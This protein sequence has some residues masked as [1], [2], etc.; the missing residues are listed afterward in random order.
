MAYP[1]YPGEVDGALQ[2]NKRPRTEGEGEVPGQGD[3]ANREVLRK[4]LT[5]MN[6][7]QLIDLLIDM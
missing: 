1:A 3:E 2:S 7:E 6:K 4:F 5:V